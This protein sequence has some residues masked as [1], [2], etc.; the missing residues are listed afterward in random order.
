MKNKIAQPATAP[1]V[2]STGQAVRLVLPVLGSVFASHKGELMIF[3]ACTLCTA[4]DDK[5]KKLSIV[6]TNAGH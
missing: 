3:D 6:M 4:C 5:A 1:Q 2:N